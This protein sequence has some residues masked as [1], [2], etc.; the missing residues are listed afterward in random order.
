MSSR[1]FR[2][3]LIL[4]LA[5]GTFF[6]FSKLKE[7]NE[8]TT[9]T[10][11]SAQTLS[12]TSFSM[13]DVNGKIVII[14]FWA[15]WCPPCVVEIPHFIALQKAFPDDIQIIGISLDETAAPVQAFMKEQGINYP[16]VMG[17]PELT[18]QFGPITGIPTTLT[19]DRNHAVIDKAVGYR[20]YAYFEG[21][22]KQLKS[23]QQN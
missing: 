19:L 17:T 21:L 5:S 6:A 22:I 10:H 12:G 4:L 2:F 16:I 18:E 3:V 8:A 15:T 11:F 20:D 13:A 23:L 7:P 1:F 9:G 14:D